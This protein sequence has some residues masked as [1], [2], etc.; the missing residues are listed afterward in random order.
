MGNLLYF[1]LTTMIRLSLMVEVLL[2]QV[3]GPTR[4]GA[5]P[6]PIW[7]GISVLACE[8]LVEN[9]ALEWTELLAFSLWAICRGQNRPLGTHRKT[10]YFMKHTVISFQVGNML[11]KVED[12]AFC[13]LLNAIHLYAKPGTIRWVTDDSWNYI[14]VQKKRQNL[15]HCSKWW[16]GEKEWS[17]HRNQRHLERKEQLAAKPGTGCEKVNIVVY[18]WVFSYLI[19][20]EFQ[21]AWVVCRS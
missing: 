14:K 21:T 10:T 20:F 17:G 5:E 4:C 19:F 7:G 9:L 8:G 1:L 12:D 11:F 6:S 3:S 15:N 18:V 16:G 13:L 2:A